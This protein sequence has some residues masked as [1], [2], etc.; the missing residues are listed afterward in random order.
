MGFRFTYKQEVMEDALRIWLLDNRPYTHLHARVRQFLLFCKTLEPRLSYGKLQRAVLPIVDRLMSGDVGRLWMRDR[1]YERVLRLYGQNDQRT[2]GWH[3]KRSEMI[4]ASEVYGVL[5]SESAR[6]E[7]MMRKLEPRTGSGEAV[8]ALM[9]GTRFEPIAKRLY[10]EKTQCQITDVS[11]VQHPR[12]NFL[13]ASPDGL[14][15]PCT[16]DPKRYG[17]LVEFKCPISRVE[18]PEIPAA[19]VHQMQLQMECTGIDECEYVEYRFKQV[20]Y[21]EW[22]AFQGAKG[23]FAVYDDGH[24]VYDTADYG[25]DRQIV[26]WILNSMKEEFVAKDPDWLPRHIDAFQAFWNEVLEHRKNGTL[27]API[28]SQIPS[29]DM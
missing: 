18:K 29:L 12:Y 4:T 24:V 6:R 26:Y 23:S 22:A 17:R 11:C 7:V 25:D 13:G 14:I 27:P 21:S 2:E 20:V 8:P 15:V 1:N 9:W 3:A 16:D 19:Y 28:K 10:E 5:G